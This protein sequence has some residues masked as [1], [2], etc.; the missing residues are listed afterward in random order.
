MR[1]NKARRIPRVVS[2]PTSSNPNNNKSTFGS[3]ETSV[4]K[5]NAL[6]WPKIAGLGIALVVAG[7]FFPLVD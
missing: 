6:S 7:Q 4:L 5:Q 1:A 2:K 3:Q